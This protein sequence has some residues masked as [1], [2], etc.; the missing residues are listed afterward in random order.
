MGEGVQFWEILAALN[1]YSQMQASNANSWI[2]EV[3]PCQSVF[4]KK[5]RSTVT[6]S[7]VCSGGAHI[8]S[9]LDCQLFRISPA[10]Q[11][12]LTEWGE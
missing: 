10:I 4:L 12:V 8:A 3:F 11:K 9:I 2:L 7:M 6:T 5:G 1:F